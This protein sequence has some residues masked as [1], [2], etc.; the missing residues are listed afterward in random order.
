MERLMGKKY[1]EIIE[2]NLG[3]YDYDCTG[4]CG[5]CEQNR[6]IRRKLYDYEEAE[7]KGLLIRL[8]CKV[9]DEIY[10]IPYLSIYKLNIVNGHGE[11]NRVYK[12]KVNEIKLFKNGSYVLLTC[13]GMDCVSSDYFNI[14]WFLTKE[15]AD[16]KLKELEDL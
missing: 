8:P 3:E 12:Q 11:N 13:D 15:Q 4:Q 7:E 6:K 2:C 14:A 5:E 1:K 9:G 10:K 16:K